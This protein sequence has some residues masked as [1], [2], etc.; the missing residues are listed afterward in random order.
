MSDLT[1]PASPVLESATRAWD[2]PRMAPVALFVFNRPQHTRRALQSLAGN[3]EFLQAPLFVFCDGARGPQDEVAVRE[4][5]SVVEGFGH[6]HKQVVTAAVNQGLARS[7]M[8]GVSQVLQQYDRV[9]VVE[10]DLVLAPA[11]LGFLNRGLSR[12]E[13][14]L[15][16]MQVA[17]H[18]YPLD[19]VG[20]PDAV[21]LPLASSWGWATWRRA[22][23]RFD[24]TMSGAQRLQASGALRQAFDL[25]G[26]HPLSRYLRRQQLGRADSW[27]IRWQLSVFLSGG[28]VV[29]PRSSLVRNG[30]FDGT[31]V[32]CGS[33]G[34]PYDAAGAFGAGPLDDWPEVV[35]DRGALAQ[36]QA[37]LA[38][39][40]RLSQRLRRRLAGF[41]PGG[42]QG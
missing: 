29:Y 19:G 4:V 17:G 23:E 38:Q 7:V 18:M 6:P 10:D 42:R 5:R 2:E 25:G 27:F 16:V 21:L 15:Q 26:A 20:G 8:T 40:D 35:V 3:P 36:V 41:R 11:F 1:A 14:A 32:H 28:L 22:W 39:Q 31:G 34:S 30:G 9:V 24:A 12:Y 33:G 13:D 37:F